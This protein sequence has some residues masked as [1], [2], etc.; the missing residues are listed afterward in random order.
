MAT[1]TPLVSSP[2]PTST[3][4]DVVPR[5]SSTNDARLS[6]AECEV[7]AV[8]ELLRHIFRLTEFSMGIPGVCH[9]SGRVSKLSLIL[10]IVSS[11]DSVVVV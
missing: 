1:E 7:L 11:I 9:V 8:P 6:K 3:S 5:L 4:G 2:P 10:L